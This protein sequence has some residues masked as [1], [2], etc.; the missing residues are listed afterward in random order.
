MTNLKRFLFASFFVLMIVSGVS[1]AA[2]YPGP[3]GFVNDFANVFS[4]DQKNNLTEKIRNFEKETSAEIAVVTVIS[5]EGQD[6]K[7]YANK[8]FN[9]W[10]IGKKG[11][12]NG[13]LLLLAVKD[14]K[15]RIETG[16]GNEGALNDAKAGRVIREVMS[17]FLK[18]N[19]FAEG[20]MAG[21]EEVM[22]IIKSEAST[23][24]NKSQTDK[25]VAPQVAAAAIVA[26]VSDA[27]DAT[28]FYA[29]I[30][31]I[32]LLS[33]LVCLGVVIRSIKRNRERLHSLRSDIG[34]K[35]SALSEAQNQKEAEEEGLANKRKEEER[36]K[37]KREEEREEEERRSR[38][39]RDGGSSFGFGGTSSGS[40]GWSGGGGGD[41]FGGGSSGGGG[42]DGGF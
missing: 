26:P 12:S 33:V 32:A 19:K 5:L 4:A 1:Y 42:D 13:I 17:P 9:K 30:A 29:V 31:V 38:R 18:Q 24:A 23:G 11:K 20:L 40:S 37:K 14:R 36:K 7:T 3:V 39:N 35:I 6:V 41:S 10:G 8:L 2:D 27:G 15:V 21:T 34:T 16:Y 25:S 28:T 22:V